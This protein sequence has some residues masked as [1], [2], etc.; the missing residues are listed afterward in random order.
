MICVARQN[1]YVISLYRNHDVAGPTHARG[2]TLYILMIKFL[3][4]VRV[5]FIRT[6]R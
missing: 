3:Y 2:G 6:I 4:L 1:F 5:A